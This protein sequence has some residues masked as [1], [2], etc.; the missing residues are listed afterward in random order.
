MDPDNQGDLLVRANLRPQ[1]STST[2]RMRYPPPTLP[3]I[4]CLWQTSMPI[5]IWNKQATS[6]QPRRRSLHTVTVQSDLSREDR[7]RAAELYANKVRCRQSRC[8]AKR[9]VAGHRPRFN[10]C[11]RPLAIV[12]NS[13]HGVPP[14]IQLAGADLDRM[15]C[16]TSYRPAACSNDIVFS[17]TSSGVNG[18]TMVV[19]RLRHTHIKDPIRT[20]HEATI[21][22]CDIYKL[23]VYSNA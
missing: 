13:L 20:P 17:F 12:D 15:V 19:H 3:L 6:A 7:S 1:L 5:A 14:I 9:V 23:C 10:L 18:L 8:V 2:N 22:I 21:H 11:D 4:L 16:I